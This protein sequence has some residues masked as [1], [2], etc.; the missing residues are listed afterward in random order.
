MSKENGSSS[1]QIK[2]TDT[3][4]ETD[5]GKNAAADKALAIIMGDE[6]ADDSD[7]ADFGVPRALIAEAGMALAN[8]HYFA[9]CAEGGSLTAM[10]TPI[11]Y[12]EETGYCSDQTGPLGSLLPHCGETMEA[13]WEF[14]DTS[15]K[16]PVDAIKYL[17]KQGF[18]WNRDFQDF[19]D[20]SVTQ[21]LV[22]LGMIKTSSEVAADK[23]M[24]ELFD[25]DNDSL[26]AQ[27]AD[28]PIEWL[29]AAKDIIG[30]RFKFTLVDDAEVP[31]LL[32]VFKA[33]EV[34]QGGHE[35]YLESSHIPYHVVSY[36]FAKVE[37]MN[38]EYS[39]QAEGYWKFPINKAGDLAKMLVSHG[40]VFDAQT[41][42]P[43]LKPAIEEALRGATGKNKKPGGPKHGG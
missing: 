4:I 14:Y 37:H 23:I 20:K 21:E 34:P 28:M 2:A 29:D 24:Q 36:L 22:N 43:K 30:S 18:V 10:I 7:D 17:Q 41:Q 16:T 31:G 13:T 42:T 1:A 38:D 35:G 9:I 11:R 40:F 12:F 3:S 39:D 33:L 32:A 8:R 6:P 5:P 25:P 15:V 27:G 26:L 19:I